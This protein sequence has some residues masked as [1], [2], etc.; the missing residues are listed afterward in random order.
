M[1]EFAENSNSKYSV[2]SLNIPEYQLYSLTSQIIMEKSYNKEHCNLLAIQLCPIN[3]NLDTLKKSKQ[4]S[5]G[6]DIQTPINPAK[7]ELQ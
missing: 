2:A 5:F 1:F 4:G 7:I 6:Y 3:G